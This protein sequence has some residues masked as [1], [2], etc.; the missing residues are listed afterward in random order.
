MT[1]NGAPVASDRITVTASSVSLAIGALAVGSTTTITYD[2]ALNPD[3]VT[4]YTGDLLPA[5]VEMRF[6]PTGQPAT[7]ENV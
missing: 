6:T 5:S 3:P 1:Q 2:L 7:V 4:G